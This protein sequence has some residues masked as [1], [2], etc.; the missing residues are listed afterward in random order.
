MMSTLQHPAARLPRLELTLAAWITAT[1]LV[2]LGIGATAGGVA[3]VAAPDGSVM[4]MPLSYLDGSPF[5]DYLVPGLVLL[6]LFGI[7]SLVAAAMV[8]LRLWFAPL[9]AFVIGS[10]QM[11]WIVVQLAIIREFSW[12]QPAMFTVGMVIAVASAV[13]GWPVVA[14]LFGR[15]EHRSEPR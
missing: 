1:F 5:A 7:G 14:S 10:G 6:G 2:V 12:L 11:I 4:Q 9:V 15:F 13:W 8:L 3:L